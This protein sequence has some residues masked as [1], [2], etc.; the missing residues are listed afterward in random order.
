MQNL[1]HAL[2]RWRSVRICTSI[3]LQ[4]ETAGPL[5]DGA[6]AFRRKLRA[7]FPLVKDMKRMFFPH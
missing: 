2:H 6:V 1:A 4:D 5:V 7:F 3:K